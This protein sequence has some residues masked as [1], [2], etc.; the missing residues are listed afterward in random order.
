MLEKGCEAL[1]GYHRTMDKLVNLECLWL[2]SKGFRMF[3][4]NN[5]RIGLKRRIIR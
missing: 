5:N 1:L 3:K 4:E 2:L